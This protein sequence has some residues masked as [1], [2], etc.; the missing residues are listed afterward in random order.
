MAHTALFT[1]TR[2]L[3]QVTGLVTLQNVGVSTMAKTGITS[4][5]NAIV[6]SAHSKQVNVA[7][8][9]VLKA[10]ALLKRGIIPYYYYQC[11]MQYYN[12]LKATIP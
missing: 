4:K 5:L 8:L 11:A 1:A 2:Q 3:N 10:H 12:H 9:N 6:V 7:Y